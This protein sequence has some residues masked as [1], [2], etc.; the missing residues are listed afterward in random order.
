M[1]T[2]ELCF[3]FSPDDGVSA[4]NSCVLCFVFVSHAGR[5]RKLNSDYSGD[6]EEAATMYFLCPISVGGCNIRTLNS[7]RF[8]CRWLF[9]S[10]K[11]RYLAYK[12]GA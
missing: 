11:Y 9:F 3:V 2:I 4:Y 8:D 7:V 6:L 12:V 5:R 10:Y 1:S